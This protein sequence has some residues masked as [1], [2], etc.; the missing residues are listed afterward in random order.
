MRIK[1]F[2]AALCALTLTTNFALAQNDTESAAAATTTENEKEGFNPG[3]EIIE[4]IGLPEG[5]GHG[6][7]QGGHGRGRGGCLPRWEAGVCHHHL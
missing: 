5:R 1:V 3:A 7:G 4:H 6:S 2:I